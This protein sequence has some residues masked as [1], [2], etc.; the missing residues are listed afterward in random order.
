MT[1]CRRT[2][3]SRKFN[4]LDPAFA[5]GDEIHASSGRIDNK[6]TVGWGPAGSAGF[7]PTVFLVP[8]VGSNYEAHATASI[9]D[10][11]DRHAI[12]VDDSSTGDVDLFR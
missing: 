4:E 8:R 12:F 11:G 5:G 10:A 6:S 7:C 2:P 3:A 9:D 1:S